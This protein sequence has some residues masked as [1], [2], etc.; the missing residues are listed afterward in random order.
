MHCPGVL[1]L[2]DHLSQQ[3]WF[4][5]DASAGGRLGQIREWWD[6]LISLGPSYGYL[7]NPSKTWLIMKPKHLPEATKVF[8][9][10]GI[11]TTTE[12]KRHLGAA[13]GGKSFVDSYVAEKVA[14]WVKEVED[15]AIIA[16]SHSQA[17]YAWVHQQMDLSHANRKCRTTVLTAT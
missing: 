15:L 16:K 6:R 12:G 11:N 13:L 5:D 10:S 14:M 17:A 7:A 3:V 9:D 4:A 8:H 2:I 1:P